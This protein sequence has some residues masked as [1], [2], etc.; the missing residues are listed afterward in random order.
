MFFPSIKIRRAQS[1]L[2]KKNQNDEM[3]KL[4]TSELTA[5]KMESGCSFFRPWRGESCWCLTRTCST[6][7]RELARWPLMELETGEVTQAARRL[8]HQRCQEWLEWRSCAWWGRSS[9][10]CHVLSSSGGKG[11]RSF[12]TR[13]NFNTS[14]LFMEKMTGDEVLLT[15]RRGRRATASIPKTNTQRGV[16]WPSGR[17][18]ADGGDDGVVVLQLSWGQSKGFQTPLAVPRF[19]ICGLELFSSR[20]PSEEVLK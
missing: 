9:E 17:L 5:Q 4:I 3:R 10:W 15:L 12:S 11:K 20:E 14:L 2:M 13:K 16:P 7:G 19:T 8:L 1:D 18:S 6:W